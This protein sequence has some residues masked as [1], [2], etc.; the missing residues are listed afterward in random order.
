MERSQKPCLIFSDNHKQKQIILK[1]PINRGFDKIF[2]RTE[3]KYSRN[4]KI[5]PI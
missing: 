4:A 3:K 5:I 2:L 1:T